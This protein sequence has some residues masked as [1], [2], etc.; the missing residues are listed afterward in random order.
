MVA[1]RRRS[2]VRILGAGPE[3]DAEFD[4]MLRAARSEDRKESQRVANSSMAGGAADQAGS[5]PAADRHPGAL[6]IPQLRSERRRQK[7]GQC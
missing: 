6:P 5:S 1:Q 3:L 4:R 2:G 7:S